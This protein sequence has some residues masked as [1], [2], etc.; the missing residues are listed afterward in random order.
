M[1]L[2][3]TTLALVGALVGQAGQDA[4]RSRKVHSGAPRV[5]AAGSPERRESTSSRADSGVWLSKNSQLTITTGRNRTRRCIRCAAG[6]LAVWGG[7][8]VADA[9]M[10]YQRLEYGVATHHRAQ[11]V[12]ADAD[13]VVARGRG[14]TSL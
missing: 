11:R 13:Q 12:G 2:R 9:E 6:D 10:V 7:L 3:R 1:S 4:R 5:G 8:V 14:D